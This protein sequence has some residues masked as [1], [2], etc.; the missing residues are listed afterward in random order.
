MVLAVSGKKTLRLLAGLVL[1]CCVF[2]GRAWSAPVIGLAPEGKADQRYCLW[3]F[4]SSDKAPVT[5]LAEKVRTGANF[6]EAAFISAQSGGKRVRFSLDCLKAGE[7]DPVV[8]EVARRLK[9]GQTSTPFAL[10]KGWAMIMRTTMA[11]RERGKALFDQGRHA[12][13]ER[14]FMRDLKLHPRDAAVWHLLAL[15]RAAQRE[16][17]GALK[18]I[19]RALALDPGNP[20]IMQDKATM[21]A[22]AGRLGKALELYQRADKAEPGNPTVQSNMAWVM[23]LMNKGLAKAQLLAAKAVSARP[24]NG[25][26]WYTLGLVYRARGNLKDAVKALEQAASLPGAPPEVLKTL[27]L[28]KRELAQKGGARRTP[29]ETPS[30]KKTPPVSPFPIAAS[31]QKEAA[32]APRP[33]KE[34]AAKL[35]AA[36]P[37]TETPKAPPKPQAPAAP[38]QPAGDKN[39]FSEVYL[40]VATILDRKMALEELAPLLKAGYK[41]FVRDWKDAK[42]RMW[43]AFYLG[44]F[45]D[46]KAAADLG[47]ELR[48]K[49][50]L[51][52][53]LVRTMK[54]GFRKRLG[55]DFDFS[56][57]DPAPRA[58]PEPKGGSPAEKPTVIASEAKRPSKAETPR[59]EKDRAAAASQAKP[60]AR[61]PVKNAVSVGDLPG[62]PAGAAPP[63][64]PRELR[65]EKVSKRSPTEAPAAKPEPK[66]AD[67]PA[68]REKAPPGGEPE[69][70]A[71]SPAPATEAAPAQNEVYLQIATLPSEEMAKLEVRGLLRAGYD[72]FVRTWKDRRGRTWEVVYLGPLESEAKAGE[73]AQ[74]LKAG[75]LIHSYDL[76]SL[77]AGFRA[78]RGRPLGGDRAG[79]KKAAPPAAP[80]APPAAHGLKPVAAPPAPGPAAKSEVPAPAEIQPAPLPR[81]AAPAQAK[82][83]QAPVE[84]VPAPRARPAAAPPAKAPRTAKPVVVPLKPA[85]PVLAYLV[86]SAQPDRAGAYTEARRFRKAGYQTR[87]S[88]W[89]REDGKVWQRVLLGPFQGKRQALLE[90]RKLQEKGMIK[91]YKLLVRE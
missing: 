52:S 9:V 43:M 35:E 55:R 17:K 54:P 88:A 71:P 29:P 15:C 6:S 8:F 11:F 68:P 40:Q 73:L 39:E 50:L 20:G 76:R 51:G 25:R 37:A 19:D 22:Y 1:L 70:K 60:P 34:K 3:L 63:A 13:A 87:L 47:E 5:G 21:L 66:P 49:E 23:S 90:A 46:V 12:E 84:P 26:F 56:H 28:A 82:A 42:G 91:E 36:A 18:A 45:R 24:D 31:P 59:G 38:A 58:K 10:A 75:R 48:T 85:G 64:P 65:P 57:K 7:L 89:P 41:P 83:P 78:K 79:Q 67:R 74:S 14:A 44:P 62:K 69:R 77:E 16:L 80:T 72:P 2:S 30:P 27:A 4:W 86:V 53:Y 32:P 81:A 61:P 33:E